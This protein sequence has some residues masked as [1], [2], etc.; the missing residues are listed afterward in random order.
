MSQEAELKDT[1]H[2][3][4]DTPHD[5]QGVVGG[6]CENRRGLPTTSARTR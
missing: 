3:L 2:D 6:Q 1:P 5:G 4:K